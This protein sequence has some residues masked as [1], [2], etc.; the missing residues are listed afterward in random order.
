MKIKIVATIDVDPHIWG[1]DTVF[2]SMASSDDTVGVRS[3]Y[4]RSHGK[5]SR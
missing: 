2:Q 1:V 5:E 3:V 4:V